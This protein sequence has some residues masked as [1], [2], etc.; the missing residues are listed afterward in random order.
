[1]EVLHYD[2]DVTGHVQGV[3][4]RKTA[5]EQAMHL[6]LTGYAMNLPDGS[7]HLEAE[8]PREALD[9]FV[10]WCRVGPPRARVA[11]VHVQEGALAG[12]PTFETRR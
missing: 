5:V 2:I 12:F 10:A 11:D 6:G 3:W 8:G 4:Y 9:R 1:M 7:V